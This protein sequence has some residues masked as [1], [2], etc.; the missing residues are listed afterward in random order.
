MGIHRDERW[1]LE[2]SIMGSGGRRMGH[3]IGLWHLP[4]GLDTQPPPWLLM[5]PATGRGVWDPGDRL[6][7]YEESKMGGGTG[8]LYC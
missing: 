3:V 7:T 1:P 5:K 8:S 4:D 2:V 6:V